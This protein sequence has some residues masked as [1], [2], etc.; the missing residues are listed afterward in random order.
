MWVFVFDHAKTPG[1]DILTS[2]CTGELEL[3]AGEG[4]PLSSNQCRML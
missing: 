2:Y 1:S 4:G 3:G